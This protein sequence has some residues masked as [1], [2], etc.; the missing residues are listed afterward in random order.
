MKLYEIQPEKAI[1]ITAKNAEGVAVNCKTRT[2]FAANEMLFA[3]PIR[4][5]EAVLDFSGK[6]LYVSL[7]YAQ[8]DGT[9]L[10]W[11]RCAVKNV[12]YQNV[13]YMVLYSAE[14]GKKINR[15]EAYRHF[16]AYDGILRFGKNLKERKVTVRDM[17]V[18]GVGI[19]MDEDHE[20][21]DLGLLNLEFRDEEFNM[22]LQLYANPVRK[23]KFDENRMIYGCRIVQSDSNIGRYLAAKQK[24]ESCRVHGTNFEY[25]KFF[26]SNKTK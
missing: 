25:G 1:T 14:D 24:S 12:R 17:S 22:S 5:E 15:R 8:E 16:L 13:L 4:Q 18:M 11:K 2:V 3:E 19:I 6:K 10:E 7:T 26:D 20:V 9:V 21:K 23:E